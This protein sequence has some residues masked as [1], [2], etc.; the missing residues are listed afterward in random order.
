MIMNYETYK[1]FIYGWM[2]IGAAVFF[3]LLKVTAPYGRH[4]SSKWGPQINN[5]L[6]WILMEAPVMV[7]LMYYVISYA[8]NQ[9][10]IF[11]SVF[12]DS[13]DSLN[14]KYI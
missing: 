6:G 3:L 12:F 11:I 14:V 8:A 2:A 10:M 7:L 4:A 9:K 1:L 5:N 13:F